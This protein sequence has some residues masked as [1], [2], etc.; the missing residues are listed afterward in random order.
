MDDYYQ[1]MI[2]GM[3]ESS[4]YSEMD[5]RNKLPETFEKRLKKNETRV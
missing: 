5:I 1:L 3:D 2:H 4:Y